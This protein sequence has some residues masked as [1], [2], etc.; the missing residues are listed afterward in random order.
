MGCKPID[1][2]KILSFLQSIMAEHMDNI[3]HLAKIAYDAYCRRTGGKSAV[4]GDF[5]PAFDET[6]ELVQSAWYAAAEAIYE[7]LEKDD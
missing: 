4:T 6:P 7:Q 1:N 3:E 2:A 5:L